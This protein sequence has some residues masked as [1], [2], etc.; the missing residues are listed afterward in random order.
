[1]CLT[2]IAATVSP[3][4]KYIKTQ[5]ETIT[6]PTTLY[7]VIR[8]TELTKKWELPN[9]QAALARLRSNLDTQSMLRSDFVIIDYYDQDAQ[10]AAAIANDVARSYMDQR[11]NIENEK[12][13]RLSTC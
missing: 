5:F 1:M 12:K 7:P 2:A 10:L 6:K 8:K 13:Q 4:P 3:S 11:K 9:R